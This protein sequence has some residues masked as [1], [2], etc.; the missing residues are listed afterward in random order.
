M[1]GRDRVCIHVRIREE[2]HAA[3]KHL[4]ALNKEPVA[5]LMRRLLAQELDTSTVEPDTLS[6]VVRKAIKDTLRP[7][8]EAL[9]KRAA[10]ACITAATGMYLGVQATHDLGVKNAIEM[11]DLA[12][13][14]A[15]DYVGR[16]KGAG[17]E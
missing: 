15:V 2:T 13:N 10:E 16:G 8:E 1:T 14:M 11:H 5:V 12:C 4:A 9:A 7:V 17:D 3:L 6:V